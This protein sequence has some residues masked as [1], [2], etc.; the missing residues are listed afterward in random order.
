MDLLVL[1]FLHVWSTGDKADG[2]IAENRKRFTN[3]Y[4]MSSLIHYEPFVN[5]CLDV[6]FERMNEF[7][8]TK[9]VFNLGYW[10]QCYAFDV[11]S[12]ITFGDRFG[13]QLQYSF[14]NS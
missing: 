14:F 2:Y 7:S 10:L 13:K 11:I 6:F 5:Q 9:D 4:S 1:A 8:Q 3:L 12:Q